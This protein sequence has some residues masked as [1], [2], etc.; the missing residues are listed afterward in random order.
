MTVSAR[1]HAHQVAINGNPTEFVAMASQ[2]NALLL[3]REC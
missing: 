1:I 2:E 3:Q